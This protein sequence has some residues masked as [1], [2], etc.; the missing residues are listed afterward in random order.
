MPSPLMQTVGLHADNFIRYHL[1]DQPKIYVASS[2]C[3]KTNSRRNAA[4]EISLQPKQCIKGERKQKILAIAMK[5][6]LVLSL[7]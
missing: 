6:T 4:Y 2:K 3:N 7:S 5:E 1:R